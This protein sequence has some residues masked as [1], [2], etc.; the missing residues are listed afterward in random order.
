MFFDINLVKL[1]FFCTINRKERMMRR[2]LL[3]M[4]LVTGL[5]VGYCWAEGFDADLTVGNTSIEAGFH[6]K[7]D[8]TD[9]FWRAGG[10]VLHTDDDETEY[11]WLE[12]DFTVGSQTLAPGLTCEVGLKG[13]MGDAEDKRDSGDVGAAAFAGRVGYVLPIPDMPDL[14][15]VFG[16]VAYAPEILSFRDTEEYLAFQT[17]IGFH[18]V[19]NAMIVVKYNLYDVDMDS[20]GRKWDIDNSNL[21]FGLVMRF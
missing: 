10:T 19:K 7:N 16:S 13:V 17:G 15:E 11:K 20:D 5:T 14:I 1:G 2:I 18:I 12:L 6:V 9:G 21:R 8:V 3:S 4:L